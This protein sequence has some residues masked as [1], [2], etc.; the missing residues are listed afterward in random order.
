VARSGQQIENPVTGERVVFTRTS[1]DTGGELLEL[2]LF[3]P[4][5][6]Y[7]VPEHVHPEMEER[8]E[9]VSGRARFRIGGVERTAGPGDVVT[10]PRG[11]PH[12]SWNPSSIEAHV[13]VQFRPAL[14]WEDFVEALFALARDGR[15]DARG[16]PEPEHAARL[17]REFAREIAAPTAAA[18][19]SRRSTAGT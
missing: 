5:R 9:V 6:G 2:D 13:R 14:R 16:V 3:W 1:A 8:F 19:S 7:R 10:V 15:T 11:T 4:R 17:M 12:I 18:W